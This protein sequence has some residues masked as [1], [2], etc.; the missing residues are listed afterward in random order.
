MESE[1]GNPFGNVLLEDSTAL[2]TGDVSDEKKPNPSPELISFPKRKVALLLAYCG[3]KYYGLVMNRGD[4]SLEKINPTIEGEFFKALVKAKIVSQD[5][6]D[7]PTKMGY[8]CASRTDKGVSTCGQVLSLRLRFTETLPSLINEYLPKDIKVLAV[9][10]AT[11]GFSSQHQAGARTYSYTCPTYAFADTVD[12]ADS[13]KISD[14]KLEQVR[15]LLQ[16]YKGTH[17]FHNFTSGKTME[18]MSSNRYIMEIYTEAPFMHEHM[19]FITIKIKGQSFMIHQI[20][21]MIGLVIAIV[22]G[23]ADLEHFDRCFTQPKCDVPKAPGLGLVLE[24]IHYDGYNQKHGHLHGGIDF[25]EHQ[26]EMTEFHHSRILPY[27]YQQELKEHSMLSWIESLPYH[28]FSATPLIHR[29]RFNLKNKNNTEAEKKTNDADEKNTDFAANGN[30]DS[31]AKS[32]TSDS[33]NPSKVVEDDSS[34]SISECEPVE[35]KIKLT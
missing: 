7:T 25:S 3:E 35:K 9:K 33:S 4:R 26:A 32:D 8:K 5:C 1:N 20:R 24:Q 6:A 27:I 29:Q 31:H 14:E 21:K 2:K 30:G 19:Q 16:R 17:S 13:Y 15:S 28:D 11:K 34:N 12:V 22:C 18:E 10:R 23:Q